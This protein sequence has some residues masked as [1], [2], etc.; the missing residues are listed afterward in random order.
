MA[1]TIEKTTRAAVRRNR[2]LMSSM[3]NR[4]QVI[5]G[6]EHYRAEYGAHD[7]LH[8]VGERSESTQR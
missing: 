2:R 1:R 5:E 8:Q 7:R 4:N 6:D 3:F